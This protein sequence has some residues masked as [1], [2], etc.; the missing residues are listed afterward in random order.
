MSL[1]NSTITTATAA[2][3]TTPDKRLSSSINDDAREKMLFKRQQLLQTYYDNL[4]NQVKQSQQ[5]L[6]QVSQ[7]RRHCE[8]ELEKA[9]QHNDELKVNLKEMQNTLYETTK[10]IRVTDDD[11]ST[12]IATL[13]KFSGKVNNF[14]PNAKSTFKCM[15]NPGQVKLFFCGLFEQDAAQIAALFDKAAQSNADKTDYM[16][17]SVLIERYLTEKIVA[18]VL[19]TG[20]HMDQSTN[21]SFNRIHR[22]FVDAKHEAWAKDLRLKTAKATAELIQ[23][24]DPQ[25]MATIEQA[26]TL[27]TKEIATTLTP[28]YEMTPDIMQRIEKLV[29]MA[30]D[31]CLPINGQ[32]D[33]LLIHTLRTND[34]VIPN[35][36]K[37]VYRHMGE[38]KAGQE[39]IYL[40]IAPVF[41]AKSTVEADDEMLTDSYIDSYTLVYPGRAI[42]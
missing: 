26:K 42:W 36:V 20:I 28:L 13:G 33:V 18:S 14:S 15:Q 37:H 27:I 31:L 38:E 8:I 11:F 21:E 4:Q 10:P 23:R 32:D 30:S 41:L 22:L 35:Q 6:A 25:I 29:D 9:K 40:S 2:S 17:V 1:A 39:K 19:K 12:I 24:K 16:L 3:T 7:Q 34:K 5:E